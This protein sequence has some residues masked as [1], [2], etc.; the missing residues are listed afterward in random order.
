MAQ[1]VPIQLEDGTEIYIE[2]SGETEALT[3]TQSSSQHNGLDDEEETVR[4]GQKGWGGGGNRGFSNLP[5]GSSSNGASAAAAQSFK[6]IEG[7]IRTYTNQT[8]NAFRNMAD[9]NIEKVTLQFGIRVGGE[10]GIPYVT[11]G[12]AESNLSITVE[13]SFKHQN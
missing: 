4:G 12:V 1:L 11:K 9:G 3:E 8:L 5:G 7:T 10:A 6:A 13:C 2:A